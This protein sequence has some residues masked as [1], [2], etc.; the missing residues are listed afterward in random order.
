MK[1]WRDMPVAKKSSSINGSSFNGINGSPRGGG[2]AG[3]AGAAGQGFGG[4]V[5]LQKTP[6]SFGSKRACTP[7][8]TPH[9]Y[10]HRQYSVSSPIRLNST[11]I[12]SE[13]SVHAIFR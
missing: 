7:L 4:G 9:S 13:K 8:K 3:A 5:R 1:K 2:G 6:S 10:K 12:Q 11:L